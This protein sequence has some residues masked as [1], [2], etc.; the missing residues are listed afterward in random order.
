[1]PRWLFA[2]LYLLME[3]YAARRDAQI[4]FL[5]A[6]VQIL[7]KKL[8]G[9]RIIHSPKDRG[10][11]LRLGEAESPGVKDI[12]G[13]VSLQTYRRWGREHE[14]GWEA[15][16]VGRSRIAKDVQELIV[17]VAR[18]NAQ[19]VYRRIVGELRKLRLPVSKST[20]SRV[21]KEERFYPEPGKGRGRTGDGT[22]QRFIQL[23]MNTLVACDFFTKA[24]VTPRGVRTAY[25]L[26]FIRLG[27]RRVFLT[28]PTYHADGL[29]VYRQAQ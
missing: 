18:E 8:P 14:R 1:M 2:L 3:R 12:I 13:I 7:R 16:T 19:W 25:Y 9:N 24:I 20:V 22:W 21:L 11:L 29:W 15:G 10:H 27:S 4:Q 26:F 23:H 6:E 5:R 17:R 28:A